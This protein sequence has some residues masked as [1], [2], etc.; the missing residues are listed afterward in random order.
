MILNIGLFVS[1]IFVKNRYIIGM[2]K[3]KDILKIYL[4]FFVDLF[5]NNSIECP[6][7]MINIIIALF[8]LRYL[9]M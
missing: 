3:V 9:R 2:N 7:Y 6:F 8:Y 5:Y 1:E 4:K